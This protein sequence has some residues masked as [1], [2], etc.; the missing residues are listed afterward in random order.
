MARTVAAQDRKRKDKQDGARVREMNTTDVLRKETQA[1]KVRVA[2]REGEVL[3]GGI[4]YKRVTCGSRPED[5]QEDQVESPWRP[6]MTSRRLISRVPRARS[7]EHQN[8]ANAN[9]AK[10]NRLT[11]MGIRRSG[12]ARKWEQQ[13]DEMEGAA[14]EG[15]VEGSVGLALVV[16]PQ[17]A[18]YSTSQRRRWIDGSG[19]GSAD[20]VHQLSSKP[21]RT[22]RVHHRGKKEII[23]K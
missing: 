23:A 22:N 13:P 2:N 12:T 18:V 16:S 19:G 3:L 10:D 6:G 15:G 17:S 14:S 11:R 21:P 20:V 4:G 7:E 1:G 8:V 5:G 9:V